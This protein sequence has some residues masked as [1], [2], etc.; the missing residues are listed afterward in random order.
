MIKELNIK[1]YDKSL[2]DVSK[3]LDDLD[4]RE[5]KNGIIRVLHRDWDEGR[6]ESYGSFNYAF[7][8]NQ[9]EQ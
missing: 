2:E 7:E 6:G 9:G 5:I 3:F 8:N 1:P 4:G